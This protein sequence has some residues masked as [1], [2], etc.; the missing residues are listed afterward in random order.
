VYE[1]FDRNY[2]VMANVNGLLAEVAAVEGNNQVAER[3]LM[4]SYIH[5]IEVKEP[6]YY[7]LTN[8]TQGLSALYTRKADFEKALYYQKKKEEFNQKKFD[9]AQRAQANKLEAQYENKR[10]I[11][12][13]RDS[14]QRPSNRRIQLYLLA[15]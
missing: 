6:S 5:L 2:D 14:E 15:G 7:N 11:A 1:R 3:Y 4:N 13:I 12:D 10:L 8:V 9:Q